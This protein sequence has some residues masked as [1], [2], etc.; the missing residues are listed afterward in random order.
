MVVR[1][2]DLTLLSDEKNLSF[3]AIV[4]GKVFANEII[5]KVSTK[6]IGKSFKQIAMVS[7]STSCLSLNSAFIIYHYF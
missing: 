4:I 6:A 2:Y 7:K 5:F 3:D 1:K